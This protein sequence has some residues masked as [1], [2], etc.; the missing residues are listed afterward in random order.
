VKSNSITIR[1]ASIRE[2]LEVHRL[3]PEFRG[4]VSSSFYED[5]LHDR[6]FLALVAEQ[7]GRLVGFKVGYESDFSEMFYSW[8]GGVLP[9]FRNQGIASK[10]AEYQEKWAIERGFCSVF[11][12]TRNRF[13]AMI[14][15]GLKRGFK[16]QKM[17]LK[18]NIEEHRILLIKNL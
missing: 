14:C 6:V 8:M 4:E 9:E 7:S 13:P 12:K 18:E 16:I 3:I 1:E 2:I 15:F 10:L 5:R 17:I 11:F